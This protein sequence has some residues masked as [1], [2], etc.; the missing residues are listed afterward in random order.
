MFYFSHSIKNLLGLAECKTLSSNPSAA[1]KNPKKLLN[2]HYMAARHC[3]DIQDPH[4]PASS[5]EEDTDEEAESYTA[6]LRNVVTR[7]LGRC[8]IPGGTESRFRELDD[9]FHRRSFLM[10]NLE[11]EKESA[12][13]KVQVME[14]TVFPREGPACKKTK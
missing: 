14:V 10:S 13:Q 9:D 4:F 6:V 12:K 8:R 5:L 1:K 7:E 11:G 3:G 2:V